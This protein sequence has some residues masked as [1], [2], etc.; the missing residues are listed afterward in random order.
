M[1]SRLAMQVLAN[2]LIT[3]IV[4]IVGTRIHHV[5][6]SA[7]TYGLVLVVSIVG[8][9]VFLS[10]GQALVGL[11][12]SADSINAAGRVLVLGL[13]LLSSLGQ[14]RDAR[15]R[16]GIDRA[17]VPRRRGHDALRRSPQPVRVGHQRLARSA[18]VRRIHRRVRRHRHPVVPM[19]RSMTHRS[20]PRLSRCTQSRRSAVACAFTPTIP[21]SRGRSGSK[22]PNR[23]STSVSCSARVLP[24][25]E[26]RGDWQAARCSQALPR[27][28]SANAAHEHVYGR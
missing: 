3:V 1:T 24:M 14:S 18:G 12:K 15:Q 21:T 16:L 13:V 11:V 6:L 4:L 20:Q 22:C 8:G 26:T 10:I 23:A 28:P 5:S 19:G 7:G 2:L 27:S 25:P 9:A 17:L